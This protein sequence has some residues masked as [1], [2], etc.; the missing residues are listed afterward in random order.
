MR[1]FLV[2]TQQTNLH[3]LRLRNVRKSFGSWVDDVEE[4][5]ELGAIVR[6]SGFSIGMD[7]FVHTTGAKGGAN[8]F[9]DSLTSID[10]GD[11]LTNT[12]RGIGALPK[13]DHLGLHHVRHGCVCVVLNREDKDKSRIEVEHNQNI[14]FFVLLD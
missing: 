13:E 11:Q 14:Y 2:N 5:H 6:N 1:Q 9:G 4:V 8:D 3:V 7:E 10:V 12:L